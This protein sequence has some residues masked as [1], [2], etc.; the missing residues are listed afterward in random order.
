MVFW[1]FRTSSARPTDQPHCSVN[2]PYISRRIG[3][4]SWRS[5]GNAPTGILYLFCDNIRTDFLKC[6]SLP[7]AIIIVLRFHMNRHY[8]HYRLFSQFENETVGWEPGT[9][10][11]SS[12]FSFRLGVTSASGCG[13]N[14]SRLL[15]Y[16]FE[17]CAPTISLSSRDN[18]TNEVFSVANVNIALRDL[19]TC[20]LLCLFSCSPIRPCHLG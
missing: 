13:L 3:S 4:R 6:T 2:G 20:I 10:L 8:Q 14:L 9:P 19:Q 7:V 18:S 16:F 17:V 5:R 11:L 1:I 15:H 12:M